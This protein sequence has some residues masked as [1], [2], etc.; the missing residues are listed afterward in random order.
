MDFATDEDFEVAN[1]YFN[2][3]QNIFYASERDA[4]GTDAHDK[5]S[6]YLTMR[7]TIAAIIRRR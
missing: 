4:Y 1:S 3:F 2:K 6:H 5:E 7:N